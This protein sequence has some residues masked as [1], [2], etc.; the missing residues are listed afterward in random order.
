MSRATIRMVAAGVGATVSLVAIVVLISQGPPSGR[1][2]TI[3]ADGQAVTADGG[4]VPGVPVENALSPRPTREKVVVVKPGT[5]DVPRLRP[6]SESGQWVYEVIDAKLS[7][8]ASGSSEA[9]LSAGLSAYIGTLKQPTN[10]P[11]WIHVVASWCLPCL[12]E[13]HGFFESAKAVLAS[14]G[15]SGGI[16]I[17]AVADAEAE[18]DETGEPNS[19]RVTSV[20]ERGDKGLAVIMERHRQLPD[21]PAVTLPDGLLAIADT[22]RSA[23]VVADL[24]VG[25]KTELR[26]QGIPLSIVLDHCG[27]PRLVVQNRHGTE[28]FA[29]IAAMMTAL[30]KSKTPCEIQ[31][32]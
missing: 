14:G 31:A 21:I 26:A 9:A 23:N 32:P 6:R 24:L 18:T 3:T 11:V 29:Q 13:L 4:G 22:G 19:G 15:A 28:S 25:P 7:G 1:V 30:A 17:A 10:G 12:W 5:G 27:E 2:R 16:V 8:G 20:Q